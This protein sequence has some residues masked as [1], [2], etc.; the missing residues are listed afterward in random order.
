MKKILLMIILVLSMSGC[1]FFEKNDIDYIDLI[2]EISQITMKSNVSLSCTSTSN[3]YFSVNNGSGIIFHE[4]EEKYYVLTNHHVTI[5]RLEY[6]NVEYEISDYSGQVYKANLISH[7]VN[8]D[9]SVLSFLK[10]NELHVTSLSDNNIENG[11]KLIAIST[12]KNQINA[13]T[14]GF[15]NGYVVAPVIS[16][17]EY[18]SD[19]KFDVLKHDVPMFEGSSGGVILNEKLEAVAIHYAGTVIDGEFVVG[20]AIPI[21]MVNEFLLLYVWDNIL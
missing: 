3:N 16:G 19:V 12:P 14:M 1:Q 18:Y 20:Y 8:Y 21:E 9:L 5:V 4:D 10:G 15:S 13:L 11:E 6:S 17:F 2:N 7:H